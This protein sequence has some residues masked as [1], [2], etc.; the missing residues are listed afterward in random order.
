MIAATEMLAAGD[1]KMSVDA[2][3]SLEDGWRLSRDCR[4]EKLMGKLSLAVNEYSKSV[5]ESFVKSVQCVMRYF[6]QVSSQNGSFPLMW[7]L[8]EVYK[9]LTRIKTFSLP[10]TLSSR[11]KVRPIIMN[12]QYGHNLPGIYQ[13]TG[14]YASPSSGSHQPPYQ[15]SSWSGPQVHAAGVASD[16]YTGYFWDSPADPRF[17]VSSAPHAANPSE[18]YDPDPP[19]GQCGSPLNG[20][21]LRRANASRGSVERSAMINRAKAAKI[22]SQR[23]HIHGNGSGYY[24]HFG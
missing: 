22:R 12:A 14:Y 2:V 20:I 8:W 7:Y 19:A 13:S 4:K 10:F 18:Y 5:I 17:P 21:S 9:L 6:L 23:R 16:I 3:H 11:Y 1:L 15:I 24:A